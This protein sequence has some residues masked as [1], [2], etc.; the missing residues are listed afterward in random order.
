MDAK[1]EDASN[2]P[3]GF[4]KRRRVYRSLMHSNMHFDLELK[5]AMIMIDY[6]S[7]RYCL[8]GRF[9]GVD[10]RPFATIVAVIMMLS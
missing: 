5:T 7:P 2:H 3:V 6:E 8:F 9:V 10:M 1:G 4:Q